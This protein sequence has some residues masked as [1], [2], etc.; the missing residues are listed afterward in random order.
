MYF[1][2]FSFPNFFARLAITL[3]IWNVCLDDIKKRNIHSV[4]TVILVPK[5]IAAT[6]YAPFINA[7]IPA[8]IDNKPPANTSVTISIIAIQVD[9][10][11]FTPFLCK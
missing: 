5:T 1:S 10:E 6:T 2:P 4:V 9:L 8:M 3:G 7:I 11:G